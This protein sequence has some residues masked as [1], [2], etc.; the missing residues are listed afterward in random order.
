MAAEENQVQ[1]SADS[2]TAFMDE[3]HTRLRDLWEQTTAALYAEE[4]ARLHGLARDLI[5][6]LK[7]HIS[8]EEQILFPVIESKSQNNEPTNAMRLEH[9]QMEH[10]L[11]HLRDLL[12]V[13]IGVQNRLRVPRRIDS[14]SARS[15][16]TLRR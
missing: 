2:I 13:L 8:V 5:A 3:E 11:E 9:R 4:F 15:L 10:M 14:G 6:A 12:E 7:R 1:A 16:Q